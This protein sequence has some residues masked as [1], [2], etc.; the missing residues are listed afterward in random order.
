MM[1]L[2]DLN[3]CDETVLC[4]SVSFSMQRWLLYP[5]FRFNQCEQTEYVVA[6]PFVLYSI[7]KWEF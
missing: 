4:F 5:P 2:S 7:G 6:F 1:R 3:C